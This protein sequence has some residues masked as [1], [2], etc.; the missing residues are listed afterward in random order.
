[1]KQK[2]AMQILIEEF[3]QA[4]LYYKGE[5]LEML[6]SCLYSARALVHID[7]EQIEEAYKIGWAK[8]YSY[9]SGV[10]YYQQKYGDE[11]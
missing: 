10:I 5:K 1:M 9:G 7:R 2:T 4:K 3:E 11:K 8:E 6:N